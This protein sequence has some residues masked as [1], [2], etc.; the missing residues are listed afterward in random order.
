MKIILGL[1][2]LLCINSAFAETKCKLDL[3]PAGIYFTWCP[4]GTLA[5][6]V[7]ALTIGQNHYARVRVQCVQP[8]VVCTDLRE[9]E[10]EKDNE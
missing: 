1:I 3:K 10:L 4:A 5:T 8:T 2:T 9:K 7:E 6:A